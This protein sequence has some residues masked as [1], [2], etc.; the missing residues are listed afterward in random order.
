MP[1]TVKNNRRGRNIQLAFH[2]FAATLRQWV[3]K[4]QQQQPK[5]LRNEP[6]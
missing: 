1:A 2:F 4:K 5:R 3:L 6:G